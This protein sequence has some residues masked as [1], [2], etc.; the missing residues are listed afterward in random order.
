MD[1]GAMEVEERGGKEEWGV[2]ECV[3]APTLAEEMIYCHS[4]YTAR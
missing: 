1:M 2:K 3:V 4:S